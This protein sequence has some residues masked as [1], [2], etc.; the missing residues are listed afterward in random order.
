MWEEE[1][2]G[3]LRQRGDIII[4]CDRNDQDDLDTEKC[5]MFKIPR[6]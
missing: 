2:G 4:R 1:R 6:R 3:G 5:C